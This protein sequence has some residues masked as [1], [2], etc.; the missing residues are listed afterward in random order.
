M[1]IMKNSFQ[2]SSL[3]VVVNLIFNIFK[4][5]KKCSESFTYFDIKTFENSECKSASN[6]K[7]KLVVRK[8]TGIFFWVKVLNRRKANNTIFLTIV[9]FVELY[10]LK[11]TYKSWKLHVKNYN[12][13]LFV[14]D[15]NHIFILSKF[16]IL[17]LKTFYIRSLFTQIF[18]YSTSYYYI[19][20]RN[21]IT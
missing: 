21:R 10:L 3:D 6:R 17:L 14:H 15:C 13:I 2:K 20:F 19:T 18:L 4:F 7:R 11:N 9:K 12:I 8:Q 5:G 1:G 16:I